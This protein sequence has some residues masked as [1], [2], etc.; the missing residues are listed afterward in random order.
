M[1]QRNGSTCKQFLLQ[2]GQ[3]CNEDAWNVGAGVREGSREQKMYLRMIQ[4]LSWRYGNYWGWATFE[5]AIDK[6]NPKNDRENATNAQ[7]RRLSLR[8]IAEELGISKDTAHTI[9]RDDLGVG[10]ICSRFVS[11]KLT[12]E[13]KAKRMET[14]GDF[15]FMCYP[16]PPLL[17][18]NIVTGDETWCNAFYQE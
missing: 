11:H 17:L 4:T 13:Q 9:V 2:I 6:Q 16:D 7:V 10:K 14:S 12:D 1:S 18:E 8:L 5:S 3:N 15:I